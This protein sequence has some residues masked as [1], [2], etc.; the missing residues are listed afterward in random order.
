ML[1]PTYVNLRYYFYPVGN[2]P[3]VNLLRHAPLLAG[4][5]PHLLLLG[6]GDVRN[7][8]YTLY[9]ASCR[10]LSFKIHFTMCDFEPAILARNILLL[11]LLAKEDPKVEI[12][13]AWC[14]YYN[15][16]ITDQVL[17]LVQCQAGDLVQLSESLSIWATSSYGK[18]FQFTNESGLSRVRDFWKKYARTRAM[19]SRATKEYETRSRT[20]ISSIANTH[21]DNYTV[22][23]FRSLGLYGGR[24]VEV[25]SDVFHSFWET[26]V[27]GG[28]SEDS[29]DLKKCNGGHVNPLFAFSSAPTGEFAVHYGTDPLL[30]FRVAE[31]FDG[32]QPG[33]IHPNMVVDAAKLQFKNCCKAFVNFIRSERAVLLFHCGDAINLCYELQARSPTGCNFPPWT[34]KYAQSWSAEANILCEAHAGTYD[35]IDT[36]NLVDHVGILNILPAVAP[37]LGQEPH[38]VLYMEHLLRA[39]EDPSLSLQTL[40]SADVTAAS[41]L[42]GLAPTGQLL[43][44]TSDHLGLEVVMD[45]FLEGKRPP[46]MRQFRL[47]VPW[48]QACSGDAVAV[49]ASSSALTG[50]SGQISM[51]PNELASYLMQWYIKIFSNKEDLSK[52]FETF[53][54]GM[55]APL[56]GDI[57]FYSRVTIVALLNLAKRNITTDWKACVELL[58]GMILNDSSLFGSGN[59]FQELSIH[60]HATGLYQSSNYDKDPRN[61]PTKFGLPRDSRN[62]VG[63]L[64]KPH[65]PGYIHVALVIPRSRL[66]IF[67]GGSGGL[68]DTAHDSTLGTPGLHLSVYNESLF[69]NRFYGIDAVFGKLRDIKAEDRSGILVDPKG[70]QGKADLIVTCVVATFPFLVGS[71]ESTRVALCVDATLGT[72]EYKSNQRVTLR[73]FD[74]GLNDTQSLKLLREAPERRSSTQSVH[75][76]Q[77]STRPQSLPVE[78]SADR[79]PKVTLS[80]DGTINICVRAEILNTTN[81]EALSPDVPVIILQSSPC[82]LELM[83]GN[84]VQTMRFP[85]PVNG[86]KYKIR[87]ARKQLWADV[88]APTS[89]DNEPGGYSLNAFPVIT[90]ANSLVPWNLSMV[91]IEQKPIVRADPGREPLRRHLGMGF[92]NAE[93]QMQSGLRPKSALLELK[94]TVAHMALATA[95]D[96]H[97]S[98]PG[99]VTPWLKCFGLGLKSGKSGDCDILLFARALRHDY[100]VNSIVID[101]FVV[102]LTESRSLKLMAP[103][104]KMVKN[105]DSLNRKI[106]EKEEEIWKKA[107]PAFVER[108]RS[109]W[110]HRTT[111]E[112]GSPPTKVP[113]S[114]AH[115]ENP[116][117]T[118]GEG[119]GSSLF[120]GK[121]ASFAKYATRIAIPV[122]CAIP[123]VE[124]M[125]LH[126]QHSSCGTGSSSSR[127]YRPAMPTENPLGTESCAN[128]G[129]A[130]DG[131]KV[132]GRCG[133]AKYCNRKCQKADWK[134][135]KKVCGK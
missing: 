31:A 80:P 2:T 87:I 89:L 57:N 67:M 94:E 126:S 46:G 82:C 22:Q 99:P 113:L 70:W 56:V 43:G 120:P 105:K 85:Y 36:S 23:G 59:S 86:Q 52:Q 84:H 71:R 111:C 30:S 14:L 8:L 66:G 32:I 63:L 28:H 108:C 60:L 17:D 29:V 88:I 117:C 16:F 12:D 125:E 6:C 53:T 11:S 3:A 128:C 21:K 54:R 45:K 123:Y 102:P 15:L 64:G 130:K 24:A 49:T 25:M 104:A 100:D 92:S 35:V 47:R 112:Y 4:N 118:C 132:C 116:L 74:A 26:G 62:E 48:R 96:I 44:T 72:I 97:R 68:P 124:S 122:L 13:Q 55:T 9:S 90:S 121:F 65:L 131:F 129:A 81:G 37:L 115:G 77:P 76:M 107:L 40:L 50:N 134:E 42:I 27:V 79:L 51:D 61:T 93:H 73:V 98:R 75:K 69:E 58:M 1:T 19:S 127:D 78:S 106:T 20:A 83:I 110:A 38:C 5:E 10:P 114:I 101:A 103:I 18:T 95:G 91:D 41:L 135:H 33:D 7:V 39:A 34:R 133:K 109:T 119:R